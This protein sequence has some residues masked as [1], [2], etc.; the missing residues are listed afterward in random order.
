MDKN[1]I[2]D[3]IFQLVQSYRHAIRAELQA[4]DL[5]LNGMHVRCLAF[6][7]QRNQCTANDIVQH[8]SRDKAQVARLVKE[9]IGN[10]WLVKSPNPEDKR[11]QFLSL[12]EQGILLSEQIDA[13]Q[14][15]I[16]TRMKQDLSDEELTV[17]TTVAQKF[18]RNLSE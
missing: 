9:M 12:T 11:S 16:Q 10:E 18:A 1:L 2:S 8:F 15:S 4:N 6:I 3:T 5:G 13:A 14:Q 17:F 7:R